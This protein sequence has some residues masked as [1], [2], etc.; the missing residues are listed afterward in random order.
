MSRRYAPLLWALLAAFFCRVVGQLLVAFWHVSFLPP[1]EQ[2][3]SGL[4]PYP[5]LLASQILII[6][7][8]TAVAIDFT[9]GHGRF[10]HPSRRAAKILT[11]LGAVYFFGMIVRYGIQMWMHP[12]WRWIG[13]TIPI[14]LHCVLATFVL[15]VGEFHRRASEQR[16]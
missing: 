15:A 14:A 5:V 1:M 13:H 2:W 6:G 7:S 9:R 10:V 11:R 12:E 16:G 8:L 3:Q 4:L